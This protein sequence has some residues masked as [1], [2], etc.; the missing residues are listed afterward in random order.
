MTD[1]ATDPI[2][3]A[4]AVLIMVVT[5]MG[6]GVAFLQT[7]AGDREAVAGRRAQE[8]SVRTLAA[9]VG[10]GSMA[11]RRETNFDVSNDL[12]AQ[13]I[14]LNATATRGGPA[15][16]YAAAL[17][18]AYG[19]VSTGVAERAEG[20]LGSELGGA[21]FERFYLDQY[22]PTY[23]AVE[24]QKAF[25]RER[26]GWGSKGSRYVTVITVFAVA[27]P[28]RPDADGPLGGPAAVPDHG[29]RGGRGGGGMGTGHLGPA[30]GPAPS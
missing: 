14:Y 21:G 4:V 6:A 25:A 26:D 27:L 10:A 15:A 16:G 12:Y 18:E 5:V 2:Q 22:V 11:G 19:R 9:L 20:L 1:E 17:A 29:H 7:Q 8:Y 30:R 3:R 13:S 28:S 24:Y 23:A